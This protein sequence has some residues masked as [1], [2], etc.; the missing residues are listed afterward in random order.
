MPLLPA[1][2][3]LAALGGW[4]LL[5][6]EQ[7]EVVPLVLVASAL[8]FGALLLRATRR[9]IRALNVHG[10]EVAAAT[11]GLVTP[12]VIVS[13]KLAAVLDAEALR[14]VR[15][16]EAAH[17]R[18][19]DPLRLWIAQVAA[20]LQWPWPGASRRF[21]AWREALELAR[22]EEARREGVEGADLA[23]GVLAAARLAE[24]P[25]PV[26]IACATGA[27][28]LLQTRVLRLL[29][30]LGPEEPGPASRGVWVVALLA[31]AAALG[32]AFG[33]RVIPAVF[34]LM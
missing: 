14:A 11:V 17:V 12:R 4:A 26:V 30:P 13:S 31:A 21:E 28:S 5:E 19:F 1:A 2:L 3:L 33:E 27:G 22:D 20:D 15:A 24:R 8:P 6:P 25:A 16:H 23:A 29:E 18:H 9:A 32:A 7:S 10:I 34:A